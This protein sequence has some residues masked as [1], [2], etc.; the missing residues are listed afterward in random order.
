MACY[1]KGRSCTFP[2]LRAFVTLTRQSLT[3]MTVFT[4]LLLPHFIPTPP[5]IHKSVP[6]DTALPGGARRIFFCEKNDRRPK[7]RESAYMHYTSIY[8]QITRWCCCIPHC[9]I[10]NDVVD[11]SPSSFASSSS[12]ACPDWNAA[13]SI[14]ELP[15]SS[16][17]QS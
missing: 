15:P 11:L 7:H 17:S 16:G 12:R 5:P 4:V 10:E 6:P 1:C 8:M 13:V 2:A 3:L 9:S 14:H